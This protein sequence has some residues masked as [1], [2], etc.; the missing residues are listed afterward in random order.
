MRQLKITHQITKR[1][2]DSLNKYLNELNKYPALLTSEE[3]TKLAKLVA[4]GDK[5]AV[6]EL[7]ERNLRFVISVA[8]QYQKSGAP[9][10]DLINEG[11]IG[12]I[13][14]AYRFDESRGFKFISYAV[15]WI[16]QAILSYLGEH[17]R[18]VRL[19]INKIGQLSKIKRASEKLA[20]ILERDPTPEELAGLTEIDLSESDIKDILLID[21][22]SASLDAPVR[23]EK[24][25]DGNAM[26]SLLINKDSANPDEGLAK[27]DL[28]FKIKMLLKQ[29]PERQ[30]YIITHYFGLFGNEQR[31]LDEIG[32]NLDL[33]KERV[34]QLK[35]KSLKQ[36]KRVSK[37]TSNNVFEFLQK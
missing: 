25:E 1:E 6:K 17:S 35:E 2:T 13:K 8:K 32:R 20:Q 29:I 9:L 27:S 30:A 18:T 24:N 11:N 3:E 37:S 10:E 5:S 7:I 19:P 34:R 21:G 26:I 36:I 22:G 15:W 23:D 14:A 28:S 31:T 12:L 33:T 16:R 4:D